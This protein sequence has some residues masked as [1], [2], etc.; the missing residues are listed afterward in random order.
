MVEGVR[1]KMA[2]LQEAL[3]GA[4]GEVETLQ[5][6]L[7]MAA[8][9][10]KADLSDAQ[11]QIQVCMVW[12]CGGVG[13]GVVGACACMWGGLEGAVGACVCMPGYCA[14]IRNWQ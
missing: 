1:A 10:H 6:R 11:L 9:Q 4:Q 5:R 3:E 8:R 13:G 14:W 2:H 7:H 12:V